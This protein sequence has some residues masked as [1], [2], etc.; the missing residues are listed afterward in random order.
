[1]K[2][3][4]LAIQIAL[5]APKNQYNKFG[6]YPYRNLEDI[7][8][9]VKPLC[10]KNKVV[11]TISDE[12]ILIGD[13]YYVRSISEL[14]DSKSG[15]TIGQGIGWAREAE[16]RKGMDASQ[17]TGASS[18]Y[19]RKYSVGGLFLIDDTKDADTKPPP[20]EEKKTAKQQTDKHWTEDSDA[21]EKLWEY[22]KGIGMKPGEVLSV[23]NLEAITDFQGSKED[24]LKILALHAPKKEKKD[25]YDLSERKGHK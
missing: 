7:L 12:M 11:L 25:E 4:L 17:I 5:K 24:M 16:S 6:N 18:S 1:M 3:K 9:A 22:T 20:D 21:V 15:D 2:D 19:A 8:E 13:R 14:W 10:E 23:L